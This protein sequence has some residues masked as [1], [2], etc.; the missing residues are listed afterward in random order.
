M[1]FGERL[2]MRVEELISLSDHLFGEEV[3]VEGYLRAFIGDT[4]FRLYDSNRVQD[5]TPTQVLRINSSELLA[6][7]VEHCRDRFRIIPGHEQFLAGRVRLKGRGVECDS[8]GFVVMDSI[9][10]AFRLNP[11][12]GI[13]CENPMESA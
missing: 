5:T 6:S 9:S 12:G 13:R 1:A 10:K 2:A 8:D 4:S 3:E 7:I 11:K